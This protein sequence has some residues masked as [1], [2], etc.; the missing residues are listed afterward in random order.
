MALTQIQ[1]AMLQD[2]ILAA[3]TEG[4]AKMADGFLSADASGRAKMA[5]GFLTLAKLSASGTPDATKFLRGDNSWIAVNQTIVKVH[6][7][8]YATRITPGTSAGATFSFGSFTP[9]N[10]ATNGFI[11]H[12]NIPGRQRGQNFNGAGI[13]FTGPTT[14]D[15]RELGMLY[16]GPASYQAFNSFNF[17]I[18]EGSIG[19]ATWTVQHYKYTND[20]DLETYCVNASDDARLNQTVATCMIIEFKNP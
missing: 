6:Y 13:R 11:V 18:P 3:S 1:L 9:V 16:T 10:A 20:S 7:L 8:T 5:D 12:A 4:R 15:F 14:H 17:I 2:A 19:Q